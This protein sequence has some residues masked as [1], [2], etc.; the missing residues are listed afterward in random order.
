MKMLLPVDASGRSNIGSG[1]S[2]RRCLPA[3]LG[4][5]GLGL[6]GAGLLRAQPVIQD[7][8]DSYATVSDMTAA[9]WRLSALDP[10]LVTTTFPTFE[11]GRA[12]RLRANPVPNAAPAVGM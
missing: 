4:V 11:Q 12:L 9:G 3:L 5:I 8:F 1:S 7:N 10:A 2:R 6:C